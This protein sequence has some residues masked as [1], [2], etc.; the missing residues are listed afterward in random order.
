MSNTQLALLVALTLS[1]VTLVAC[2]R[3]NQSGASQKA[4]G[5]V[6]SAVGEITGDPKLKSDG[7]KDEVVGGFK[8]V[9]GDVKDTVKDAAKK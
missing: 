6:E 8:T 3:D 2:D 7:K 4:T 5:R 9:V 1:S